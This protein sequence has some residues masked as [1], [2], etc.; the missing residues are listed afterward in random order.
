MPNGM[1]PAKPGS[2]RMARSPEGEPCVRCAVLPQGPSGRWVEPG[3]F[4]IRP[5]P[6]TGGSRRV[7]AGQ[8]ARLGT[9]WPGVIPKLCLLALDDRGPTKRS[10]LPPPGPEMI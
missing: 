4:S 5:F 9:A 1:E 6:Q 8:G 10:A 2:W 7:K 3:A